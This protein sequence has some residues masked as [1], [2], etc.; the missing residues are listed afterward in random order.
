M[1]PTDDLPHISVA[2]LSVPTPVT[3]PTAVSITTTA[4]PTE[5]D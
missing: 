4:T 2:E 3:T 5:A 1:G